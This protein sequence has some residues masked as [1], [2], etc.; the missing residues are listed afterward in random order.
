MNMELDTFY[1]VT[2]SLSCEHII[3]IIL[4]L[5][6]IGMNSYAKVILTLASNNWCFAGL[7]SWKHFKSISF[8]LPTEWSEYKDWT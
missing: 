1:S 6:A 3:S 8:Y 2:L 7:C 5:S 4:N